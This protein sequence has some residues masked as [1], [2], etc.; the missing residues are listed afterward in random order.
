VAGI[1]GVFHDEPAVGGTPASELL[2]RM[3]L[4]LRHRGAE[5]EPVVRR[6]AAFGANGRVI[7]RSD[8]EDSI[9]VLDGALLNR[10]ELGGTHGS[11]GD[12]GLIASLYRSE[13]AGLPKRLRGDFALAVWD[14]GPARGL[15]ARDRQ[16]IKPLYYHEHPSGA[17]LFSSE[18]KGLLATGLVPPELDYDAIEAYLSFGFVPGPQT[19]VRGIRK[20][21]L[22]ELLVVERGARSVQT[23]WEYPTPRP[24]GNRSATDFE[25]ET[26]S[27]LDEAVRLRLDSGR[28]TGAMLSGGLDSALVVGLMAR[29]TAQ[30]KTFTVAFSESPATNELAA[31]R[32][33]ART[34]GTDHDEVELSFVGD[35][36][37][38]EELAWRMD[39]PLAE[40][41]PL[42]LLALAGRA[43]GEVE[44]ALSG[45][46]ADG[47][48]GGLPHHRTAAV[49]ARLD[50]LP[51]PAKNAAAGL[52]SRRPGRLQRG[53]RALAATG[54]A[55][56]FLAQCNGLGEDE[57]ARL[58]VGPLAAVGGHAARRIVEQ[59]LRGVDGH[60]TA[61]YIFLDEQLA[62]VDSVLHYNDRA[63]TGGPVD[64]RFP[65]LDQHL[66][67]FAA[68]I[69]VDLKVHR[70][71]RKY[72][73]R[74]VARRIVPDEVLSRPKVGFF[75]AAID[76]WVQAQV[77]AAVAD[78]LLAPSPRYA[79]FLSQDEVRRIV[80][81]HAASPTSS[82]GSR[83][84]GLLMLEV[85]LSHVVPRA[86]ALA[87]APA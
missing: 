62:A 12:P 55:N 23:Y 71:E 16:G 60:P 83:L 39:E 44:A 79:E 1:F 19:V 70:L 50:W 80:T 78:Y 9:A 6:G 59:R 8:D 63:S 86:C 31:A 56:R 87:D 72:L 18:L 29:H 4:A 61:T 69:P 42:G 52:F 43:H 73:L 5:T 30:V 11:E 46:G 53:T 25:D 81:A 27:R 17:V 74:R 22:G 26:L 51:Q 64:I 38:V 58:A 7:G 2:R 24:D 41:S 34:F 28:A 36:A 15:L 21:H 20:L 45:Q 76:A 47:I 33:I 82:G 40:L 13:G 66:V 48:F 54:A 35:T 3:S 67:E 10:L 84:F 14:A 57:R 65:F 37:T 85:W 75:N 68:T 77:D 49:A 32:S